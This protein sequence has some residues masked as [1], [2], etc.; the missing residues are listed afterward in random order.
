MKNTTEEPAFVPPYL[1]LSEAAAHLERETG[2]SW[3]PNDLM[4][5]CVVGHIALNAAVRPEALAVQ[6]EVEDSRTTTIR[7]RKFKPRIINGEACAHYWP[8]TW[9][10]GV[11]HPVTLMHVW[12]AGRGKVA[13][14]VP[15]ARDD[16]PDMVMFVN[17]QH[18]LVTHEVTAA[19]LR[20]SRD[21]LPVILS[22]WKAQREALAEEMRSRADDPQ[23]SELGAKLN[24]AAREQA[25]EMGEALRA[26]VGI[27]GPAQAAAPEAAPSASASP[28]ARPEAVAGA[29]EA[30]TPAQRR[31]RLQQRVDHWKARGVR[32]FTKR[33]AGEEG[34]TVA[35]IRQILRKPRAKQEPARQKTKPRRPATFCSGLCDAAS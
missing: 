19:D 28:A 20:V 34:V 26:S 1:T 24:E 18:E 21:T 31:E 29:A 4:G 8:A 2:R 35:R 30:E 11:A 13:H 25:R 22:R 9:R 33:V 12:Q 23:F 10:M 17:E 6:C 27:H 32:D 15:T 5:F 14:A 7:P 3:S 16:E